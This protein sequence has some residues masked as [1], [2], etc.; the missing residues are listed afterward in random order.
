[1]DTVFIHDLKIQAILGIHPH[2]RLHPQEIIVNISISTD[3][4]QAAKTDRI[5]ACVDYEI[6]S[7]NIIKLVKE[8]ERNTVEALA[9]DIATLCLKEPGVMGVKVR[10]EKPEALQDA[11]SAGVEI[12][13]P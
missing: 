3:S 7:K 2:E 5:D 12:N 4:R 1:M 9:E 13:R 10:V 8:A 6:L 11:K